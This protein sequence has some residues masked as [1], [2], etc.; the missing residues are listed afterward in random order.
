MRIHEDELLYLQLAEG[1]APA[2][3]AAGVKRIYAKTDGLYWR[4]DSGTEY[5]LVNNLSKPVLIDLA[6]SGGSLALDASLADYF[7]HTLTED[8]T[9]AISN[10]PDANEAQTISIRFEQDGATAYD[11]TLPASFKPIDGSDTTMPATL[12]GFAL[13]VAT[14]F[15]QGTR[16]EYSWKACG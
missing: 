10:P 3:P 13:L 4:D 6:S 16:W 7:T 15:D 8:T 5:K 14:T 1:A 2:D 12:G 9:L 11:V